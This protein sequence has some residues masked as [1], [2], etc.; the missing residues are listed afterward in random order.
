MRNEAYFRYAAVTRDELQRSRSRFDSPP[1]LYAGTILWR[2][3]LTVEK[4][5]LKRRAHEKP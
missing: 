3:K 2:T 5:R 1:L 4:T